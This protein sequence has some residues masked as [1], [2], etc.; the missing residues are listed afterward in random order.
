LYLPGNHEYYQHSDPTS[1][2][3]P[4]TYLQVEERLKEIC[5][6]SPKL[7]YLNQHSVKIGGIRVIGATLWSHVP[8]HAHIAVQSSLNDYNYIWKEDDET[9]ST[10]DT[11]NWHNNHLNFIVDQID[12]SIRNGEEN[13]IVLSH[14][15]PSMTGTSDPQYEGPLFNRANHAFSTPLEYLFRNYGRAN[16]SNIHTWCYGHTH[17]NCTLERFGTNVIA[18]QRGYRG[19][20]TVKTYNPSFTIKIP[21]KNSKSILES[22]FN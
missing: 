16:N 3:K 20:N 14:Y 1:D 18:N 12:S 15:S 7:I 6:K 9:I 17:F 19:S 11:S 21:V 13:C 4:A 8:L 2:K 10:M 22:I 5:A